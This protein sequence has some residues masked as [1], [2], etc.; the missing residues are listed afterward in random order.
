MKPENHIQLSN[1]DIDV[2][3]RTVGNMR[4][5]FGHQSVGDNILAGIDDISKDTNHNKSCFRAA[6]TRSPYIKQGVLPCRG[7]L[8]NL[9]NQEEWRRGTYGACSC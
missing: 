8:G 7:G 6:E 1:K 3:L 5:F 2:S 4:Y 9:I